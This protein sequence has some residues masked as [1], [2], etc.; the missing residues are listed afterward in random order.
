MECARVIILLYS[1][2]CD[3]TMPATYRKRRVRKRR[4]CLDRN[5]ALISPRIRCVSM[6]VSRRAR[7]RSLSLG[8]PDVSLL[9]ERGCG[10]VR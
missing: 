2:T 4:V 6:V 3:K 1:A 8:A 10:L 9:V 7:L 5:T